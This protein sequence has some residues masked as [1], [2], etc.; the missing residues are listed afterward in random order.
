MTKKEKELIYAICRSN[1][2]AMTPVE[3]LALLGFYESSR[4]AT[5]KGNCDISNMEVGG[6]FTA[7]NEVWERMNKQ[8]DT[9][10]KDWNKVE[11]YDFDE[12]CEEYKELA[13]ILKMNNNR[14]KYF[15]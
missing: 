15:A 9:V 13:E 8:S 10:A 7:L 11:E 2:I 14:R 4:V 6:E 1:G 12:N 3:E 5:Q